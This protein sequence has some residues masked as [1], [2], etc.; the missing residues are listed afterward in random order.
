MDNWL[1]SEEGNLFF[2][3]YACQWVGLGKNLTYLVIKFP[4]DYKFI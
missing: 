3:E 4:R 2:I 1:V